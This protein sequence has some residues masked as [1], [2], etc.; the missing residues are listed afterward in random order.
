MK[1]HTAAGKLTWRK[2]VTDQARWEKLLSRCRRGSLDVSGDAVEYFVH[3]FCG[4]PTHKLIDIANAFYGP[5][6]IITPAQVVE[7][8]ESVKGITF[9]RVRDSYVPDGSWPDV[10]GG[11][12]TKPPRPDDAEFVAWHVLTLKAILSG[13][14]SRGSA[15]L[16]FYF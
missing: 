11:L 13:A 9:D 1:E 12:L 10:L 7:I 4:A 8:H 5:A 14:V 6:Q 15:L 16:K 2:A 3:R